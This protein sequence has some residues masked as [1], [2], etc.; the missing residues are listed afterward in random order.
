MECLKFLFRPAPP[1]P[2]GARVPRQIPEPK[3]AT[4]SARICVIANPGS[5]GNARDSEAIEGAMRRFGPSAELR[6]WDPESDL[7]ALVD[8]AIAEGFDIFV[9]AG[10]D[11]TVMA[12][13]MALTGKPAKLAVLPLGTFNY[14]A[15]GLGLPEDPEAAADA[16][17]GGHTRRIS[18]GA[19]NGQVFLNNASVGIYPAIL[20]ERETTYSRFGRHRLAAYWSVL[21][22][23]IRFQRPAR[24]Q[25][26]ADGERRD[27]R[28]PLLF[29]ARSAYQ[30]EQFGLSGRDAISADK[31]AV[32]VAHGQTRAALFRLAW[33]LVR[34]RLEPGRDVEVFSAREMQ[35]DLPGQRRL[36]AFD[37]EKSH[38]K[39]P[40]DFSIRVDA[41]GIVVPGNGD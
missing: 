4:L 15:R 2:G 7:G 36:V 27:L 32:F 5:G 28:S 20:V 16:I 12:L 11:G 33:R 14:F 29:V 18:V 23:F 9:A 19:V 37:G 34:K 26:T 40:L 38:M 3:E 41:L 17:L 21:K 31:F 10:G 35:V 24:M 22:T 1:L 8:T 30:L 13:A 39:M 25:I 6:E